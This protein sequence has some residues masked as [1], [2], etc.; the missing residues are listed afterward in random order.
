MKK[1][2]PACGGMSPLEEACDPLQSVKSDGKS[3]EA[4][5]QPIW[6]LDGVLKPIL[7]RI[8]LMK[9][10]LFTEAIDHALAHAMAGDKRIVIMGEDVHTLRL[11]LYA[12]FG[13]ERVRSTPISESAYLGAAV[14]AAMAGLRPVAEIMLVD[15]LGVAMDALLNH[16]AKLRVFSGGRWTVPLVVRAACGGGYGDGG[17]HEQTLWGWLAH[18]PGLQVV[19]PSNPADAG[20]LML[21]ALESPEP[22]VFLEHKMLSELWLDYMGGSSRNGV[23]FDLPEEGIK[24]PVPDTWEPIPLGQAAVKR[25]GEDLMIISLGMGVH[26]GLS[27][28]DVLDEQGTSTG[29]MDL[30]SIAPLDTEA[31]LASARDVDGILVVDEDYHHFGLSGEIGALLL[32]QRYRGKFARVCTSGTIPYAPH[33]EHGVLPNVK[34][35]VDVAVKMMAPVSRYPRIGLWPRRWAKAPIRKAPPKSITSSIT[36]NQMSICPTLSKSACSVA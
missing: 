21:G 27:A 20:G 19:V 3:R 30:R 23:E 6:R 14:A 16:A 24:G 22:V 5:Q 36:I 9:T 35:I 2:S 15:F 4:G 25:T 13:K 8:D 11:N 12:R 10:K 18:I 26:Q 31:I 33:L 34:R 1:R 7:N 28:A 17:Q 32:E 29:V